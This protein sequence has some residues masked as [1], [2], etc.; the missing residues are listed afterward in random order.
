[1]AVA[2]VRSPGDDDLG[3]ELV[4]EF[5]DVV[6]DGMDVFG[7]RIGH[8]A[9]FA[10]VEIE[11]DGRLDAE[12]PAGAGGF[13]ATSGGERRPGGNFGE[14]VYAFFALG[15]DGE[16]DLDAFASV[17]SEDGTHEGFVVGMSEDGEEDA[18]LRGRSLR[19]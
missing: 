1:M 10:V 13:G 8:G 15:G 19:L 2:A 12:F 7:E 16:V 9:E 6:G 18:R 17:T 5:P 11:E 4:D 3:V 14:S